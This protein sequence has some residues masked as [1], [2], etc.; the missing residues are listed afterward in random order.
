M[1]SVCA[2]AESGSGETIYIYRPYVYAQQWTDFFCALW[3]SITA[4]ASSQQLFKGPAGG[5]DIENRLPFRPPYFPRRQ[6]R[7]RH[8]EVERRRRSP[9]NDRKQDDAVYSEKIEGC[10]INWRERER[11]AASPLAGRMVKVS[12]AVKGESSRAAA[13]SRRARNEIIRRVGGA[14]KG[15]AFAG[16]AKWPPPCELAEVYPGDTWNVGS[17]M[18]RENSMWEK[19][20][21]KD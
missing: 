16:A 8:T 17:A 5:F 13:S 11:R 18:M 12:A 20:R 14:R 10:W 3:Q 19:H 2:R 1:S 21:G 7:R 9:G 15:D 6:R 4:G